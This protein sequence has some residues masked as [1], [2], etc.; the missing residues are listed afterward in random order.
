[1]LK[2]VENIVYSHM[3]TVSGCCIVAIA[4]ITQVTR[5]QTN[6]Q[7]ARRKLR[8]RWRQVKMSDYIQ[9]SVLI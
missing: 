3:V 7:T 2:I 5:S 1:M 9:C 6:K 8:C 4:R